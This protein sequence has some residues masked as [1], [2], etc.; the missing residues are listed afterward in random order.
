[1]TD[2]EDILWAR[3]QAMREETHPDD[4][5]FLQLTLNEMCLITYAVILTRTLDAGLSNSCAALSGKIADVVEQQKE[6]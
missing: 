4:T 5:V 6:D 1:M 2:T 3:Q